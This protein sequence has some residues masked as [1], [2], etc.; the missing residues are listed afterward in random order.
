MLASLNISPYLSSRSNVCSCSRTHEWVHLAFLNFTKS[1]L[2]IS[3]FAR[4]GISNIQLL[5]KKARIRRHLPSLRSPREQNL[6]KSNFL[7]PPK[8]FNFPA[9]MQFLQTTFECCHI[10]SFGEI[11]RALNV[12]HRSLFLLNRL[13]ASM[14]CPS[15][16]MIGITETHSEN[17]RWIFSVAR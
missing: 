13:P 6:L 17:I 14:R 7:T 16:V 12:Y 4:H 10:I 8:S 2:E 1:R 5:H 9:I 3:V 11:Y 15:H